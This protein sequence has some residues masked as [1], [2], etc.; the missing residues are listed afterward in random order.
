MTCLIPAESSCKRNEMALN[1]RLGLGVQ[2][3]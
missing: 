2:Y 3:A 1:E